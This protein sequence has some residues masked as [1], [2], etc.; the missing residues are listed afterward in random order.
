MFWHRLV[1][2]TLLLCLVACGGGSDS[3]N[4]TV[5]GAGLN[6]LG[7]S[8]AISSSALQTANNLLVTVEDGPHGFQLSANANI[9]YATVTVCVPGGNPANANDC[10]SIDHVQVD[11]GSVGLR[12]LASK[13]NRLNL[14]RVQLSAS[15]VQ[16][17]WECYPFVIGGLW[18]A[19]AV[20]DVGLGRQTATAVPIQL[21]EDDTVAAVQPTPDCVTAADGNILASATALGSNGILGIGS[22]TLDC[23][24]SCVLGNYTGS[25]V[26]YY[27]CPPAAA[28]SAAC[29]AAA[30]PANQQ[31]Y[32]PVAALPS[33]FNNGVVLKMP[34]L[35]AA[36]PVGAA[37]ASGELIFGIDSRSDNQRPAGATQ[38]F[39]GVDHVN[40][41]DSYLNVTTRY[42]RLS[43]TKSYLDTGT[44]GLF[45]TDS[46]IP[47]CLGSSWYCPS[48]A[49]NVSATLSDG[50][51]PTQNQ[52]VVAFQIGNA[53]ALFSTRNTVFANAAGTAPAG[54]LAFAWGMPFF[55]G[56][57]V[58]MSI[59]DLAPSPGAPSNPPWYA[60][61]PL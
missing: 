34:G 15:P 49:M 12:V 57:R 46:T 48:S 25:F 32:N 60:W 23:G 27:S 8:P 41:P 3:S 38:V 16:N 9:L 30:V 37:S 33:G 26:Q 35:P 54:S 17:A 55:Y 4:T 56:K 45:F 61:A 42:G 13:V 21:I 11:T 1:L 31:V 47:L 52:V 44:N 36:Q 51:V 28:N 53:E 58:F 10:Q 2:C 50:D 14:P 7:L 5:T 40:H 6:S 24:L 29:S 43:F 39:L 18:G 20:A 59:W 22:T 19:N